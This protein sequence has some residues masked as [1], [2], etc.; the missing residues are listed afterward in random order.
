MIFSS[1]YH[2]G[3]WKF[4]S[5]RDMV[6]VVLFGTGFLGACVVPVTF[7]LDSSAGVWAQVS[8]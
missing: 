2:S 3:I 5:Y 4:G 1:L 6:F 7:I 8:L